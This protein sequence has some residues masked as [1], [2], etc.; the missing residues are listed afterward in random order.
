MATSR[1]GSPLSTFTTT[2]EGMERAEAYREAQENLRRALDQRENRLFDPQLLALSQ[3]FATPTKTGS[4]GEVI[5][6]VAGSLKTSQQ[7]EQN[8]AREIAGMRLELAKQGLQ[9]Q[10]MT[11]GNEMFRNLI[12]G[13]PGASSPSGA[14]GSAGAPG[15]PATPPIQGARQVTPQDILRLQSIPGQEKNA[16]MLTDMIKLDRD[17]F[18]ISMQG[19]VFDKDKQQYLNLEIPGQ[20]QE[21]FTTPSGQFMMTPFEYNQYKKAEQEGQ[22]PQWLDRFRSGTPAASVSGAPAAP[23]VTDAP[24]GAKPPARPTVSQTAAQA[25]A[26]KVRASET[27]KAEVNRTQDAIEAGRGATGLLASAA[28]LRSIAGRPDAKEI[29]GIFNRPDFSTALL[30]LVQEGV[31]SPGSTT[32]RAGALE[33]TLRNIGLPQDQIDRYRFG[34][35]IMA[36]IQLEQAKLT[37]GQGSVSNF[38]RSLFADASFSP[39]DNPNTILAKLSMLEARANF[40]RQRGAALRRSKMDLDD[41]MDTPEAQ[42]LTQD[43]LAQIAQIASNIGIKVP[44]DAN[45]RPRTNQ[46]AGNFGPAATQLRKELGVQ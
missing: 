36:R 37:S 15:A 26:E 16:Q 38:E 4:F 20:K 6:N 29:F 40:D 7:E 44:N 14:P 23:G 1:T 19:I 13:R 39:R 42:K 10:Q 27:T 45:A 34:L 21:P 28:A 25:E 43:Y 3:A 41:Y 46:P 30:N 2:P 9:S 18:V 11:E 8:E 33:D 12:G 24:T 17:R 5:G 22:G 32:I 31:Q 35:S